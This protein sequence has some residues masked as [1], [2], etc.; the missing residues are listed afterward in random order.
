MFAVIYIP[1]FSLQSVLRHEP[2]LQ[3]A[4][5][6]L[7]R[8]DSP[9][10]PVWQSTAAAKKFGIST[11]VTSTQ[12]KARCEQILFRVRSLAQE[13]AAQEILLEC[14][15]NSAAY[16]ESTGPGI[17][18]LDL[19]GLPLLKG[20]EAE[21]N[22]AGWASRL[23]M[24]LAQFHFTAQIGVAKA[25]GLALQAAQAAQPF[26]LIT[27]PTEFWRTLPIKSVMPSSELL[28]ILEKWGIATVGGFLALGKD[29]VA[30]RLGPEGV[31]LFETAR[32]DTVRPL[33][34]TTPK[35]I[36]EETFEFPQPIEM[37]EPLLFLVR[38][39]LEQLA[40]RV[41]QTSL[42]IE[43]VLLSLKLES[44]QSHD[45][46]LKIPAATREVEVLFRILHNYLETVRTPAPI[47]AITLR[48]KPCSSETQQ[49]Q[50]FESAVR[51]PNRFYETIGRL[52][53]LLGPDRV[54]IPVI[55]ES[56]RPDDFKVK[57][58][59]S[60]RE[61]SPGAKREARTRD[62]KRPRGPLLRRFR[63]PQPARV[64]LQDA[65]PISLHSPA[66]NSALVKARGPWRSSGNWWENLWAR[67][68]W[69]VQTSTGAIYR[70]FREGN[71]WFIEGAYD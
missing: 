55:Q 46:S 61:S 9:K 25:P 38:R 51:D 28:E 14:A 20:R 50:L 42:I 58:I 18:T 6:A 26:L 54:G 23:K 52:C 43:E 53:A 22:L 4:P 45:R 24:R 57:P 31:K 13:E 7:L 17:G 44:G 64:E 41:E 59:T 12:A 1:D 48:A 29:K 37:L 36:Y 62:V 2:E 30:E 67:E 47:V 56:H 10:S 68:E 27:S 15:Y 40:R 19:R 8:D 5:V 3:S 49:F 71:Y 69:D 35:Q 65:H 70:V 11:G 66:V 60:A 16:L 34:L 33:N 32:S 39:L 63:P 21:D